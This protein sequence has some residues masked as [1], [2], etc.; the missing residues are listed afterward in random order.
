MTPG[1]VNSDLIGPVGRFLIASFPDGCREAVAGDLIEEASSIVLP[2]SGP[3]AAKRWLRAQL[4]RTIPGMLSLHFRQKENDDMKQAKWI[5]AG[6]LVIIGAVQAWDSGVMAAPLW[7]TAMVAV[8]IAIGVAGVFVDHEGVR[9]GIGVAVLA[10]LFAA[11]MASP[12]NLPE[13]SLVGF[14]IFIM[15]IFG[16][17]F[18]AMRREKRGPRGPGAAA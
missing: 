11:R 5:A 8:A 4:V 6:A 15:L 2:A 16:G 7:I 18:L 3:V 1:A 10:I 17:R 12:V 14:P 9:F 13:L